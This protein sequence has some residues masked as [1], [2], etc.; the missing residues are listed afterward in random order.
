MPSRNIFTSTL[1]LLSQ[2]L[3]I[4]NRNKQSEAIW[5]SY[6]MALLFSRRK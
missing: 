4:D 3:K 1:R 6:E 5:E 2:L